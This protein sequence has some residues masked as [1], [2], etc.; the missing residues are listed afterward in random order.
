MTLLRNDPQ[1]QGPLL[2]RRHC[3]GCHSHAD[4]QGSGIVA[5]EP[6]APNLYGFATPEWIAGFLD[7]EKIASPDCFGRTKFAAGEM[8]GKLREL[9]DE[10]D[11]VAVLRQQLALVARALSAEARLPAQSESDRRDAR[12]IAAGGDLMRGDLGCT[13]C[14]RSGSSGELGSAP[15][16]TGYGSREWLAGMIGNPQH[17][18]FYPGE[19]ND[20]MPAFA[21]DLGRP[22]QNVLSRRELELLVA[23]LRGEWRQGPSSADDASRAEGQDRMAASRAPGGS[24]VPSAAAD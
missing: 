12:R 9:H 3:A 11:D 20:R 18:R 24:P 21:R 8:A 19:H 10:S 16:L 13:D 22:E 17:E 5:H 1:T 2:F 6:S 7:P 15:D 23:W 14:H 4:G